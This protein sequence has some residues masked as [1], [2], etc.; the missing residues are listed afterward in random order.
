MRLHRVSGVG[1]EA[2]GKREERGFGLR[3]GSAAQRASRL[4]EHACQSCRIARLTSAQ[5]RRA[6]IY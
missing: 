3:A 6:Q 5:A 2:V 1:Q 4:L